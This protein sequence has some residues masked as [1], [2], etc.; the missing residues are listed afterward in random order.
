[1]YRRQM[2]LWGVGLL[3]IPCGDAARAHDDPAKD[4]LKRH[5]GTWV[6]ISSIYEGEE[7]PAKITSS[8]KRI[9]TGD[10][11]VWQRDGKSFAGTRIVLDPTQEPRTIDVIPEGGRNRGEHIPGIYK[12]ERDLLTICMAAPGKPRPREFTAR[13]GSE[14]TLRVFKREASSCAR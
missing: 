8:I 13:K 1:M 4:E 9:V 11:V 3:A 7:A 14:R 12:L 6:A 2:I 5:E 10:R